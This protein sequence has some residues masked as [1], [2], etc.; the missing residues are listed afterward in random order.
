MSKKSHLASQGLVFYM[1]FK[2]DILQEYRVIFKDLIN[3]PY[4]GVKEV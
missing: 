1:S 3:M 4:P 2:Y